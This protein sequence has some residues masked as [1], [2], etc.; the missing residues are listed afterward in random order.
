MQREFS[1]AGHIFRVIIPDGGSLQNML[2]QYD[3]FIVEDAGSRA[4]FELEIVDDVD[5]SGSAIFF[6]QP[7]EPGETKIVIYKRGEDWLFESSPTSEMKVSMRLWMNSS[8]TLSRL[9]ILD[10]SQSLFALNNA[11]MLQYAF[12]TAELSTL[13]MHASVVE[14]G[15]KAYLFLAKSGTGKSTHSRMWLKNIP[16]SHLLNDDNPIVRVL[17]DGTVMAFGSPWSGKTPCYHNEAY[18][19]GAMVGIKRAPYNRITRLN[20]I[21]SYAMLY[22]STSGLKFDGKMSDELHFTLCEVVKKVHCF[23]LECLPDAQAALVC[24]DGVRG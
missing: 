10:E 7:T 6:D 8:F 23:T 13:E 12:R 4:I 5:M 22:S 3:T 1:V 18:P 14:N 21:N 24:Y 16:G 19:V 20:T 2:G 15:G 11:L 17:P 9:Q